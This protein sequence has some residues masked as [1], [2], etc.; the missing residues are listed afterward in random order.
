MK[1]V[2]GFWHGP[3]PAWRAPRATTVLTA[4]LAPALGGCLSPDVA[5]TAARTPTPVLL[6]P[7]ARI[8][9]EGTDS[10]RD[11]REAP[12]AEAWDFAVRAFPG[13]QQVVRT[14]RN[15]KWEAIE[16]LTFPSVDETLAPLARANPG[17]GLWIDSLAVERVLM[18]SIGAIDEYRISARA[19]AK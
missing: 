4:L 14:V 7:V 10:R 1:S 12:T 3:D 15:S 5:F 18:L 16:F 19:H 17:L 8:S 9:T 2:L 6:G 13:G 11:L